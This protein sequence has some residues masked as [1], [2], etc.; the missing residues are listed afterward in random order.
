MKIR[1][2]I[3]ALGCTLSLITSFSMIG[4]GQ[5]I[6]SVDVVAQGYCDLFIKCD[7]SKLE[8]VG[9]PEDQL[10][11]V[12]DETRTGIKEQTKKAATQA[13]LTLSDEQ[14]ESMMDAEFKAFN[15]L[16]ISTEKVSEED[17]KATVKVTT[18]KI[19]VMTLDIEAGKETVEEAKAIGSRDK[20]LLVSSYVGKLVEKL[21]NAQ[22]S[23]ETTSET[24]EFKLVEDI[25]KD[26]KKF[27]IWVPSDPEDFG[28]RLVQM[29]GG[30]GK[31]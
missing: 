19:D 6:E 27:K 12:I 11:K 8:A 7:S 31:Q 3:I 4:C 22:P 28:S 26:G 13:R 30:E 10:E 25:D 9:V 20:D 24:F 29:V 16:T 18:N 5:K 23:E 21:N 14:A 17:K 2:K 15:N 1:E